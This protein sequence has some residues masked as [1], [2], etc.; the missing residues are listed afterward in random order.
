VPLTT[1]TFYKMGIWI[2][3]DCH[4]FDQLLTQCDSRLFSQSIHVDHC[5]HNFYL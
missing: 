5:L 1:A 2:H 4:S 3:Q